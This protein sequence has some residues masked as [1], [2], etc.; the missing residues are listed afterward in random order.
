MCKENICIPIKKGAEHF[1]CTEE[2]SQT[3][4]FLV[5]IYKSD[6][7]CCH[8]RSKAIL[9]HLRGSE[10]LLFEH[11]TFLNTAALLT[12]TSSQVEALGEVLP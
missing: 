6:R 11:R 4:L 8:T 7:D 12:A 5:K 9:P 2:Y 10:T 1:T 3:G